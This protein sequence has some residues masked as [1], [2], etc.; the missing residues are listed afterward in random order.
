MERSFCA[1]YENFALSHI[2][3]CWKLLIQASFTLTGTFSKSTLYVLGK[4]PSFKDV[5]APQKCICMHGNKFR[6]NYILDINLSSFSDYRPSKIGEGFH[7]Y[8]RKMWKNTI[9]LNWGFWN[10]QMLKIGFP[11]FYHVSLISHWHNFI[12]ITSIMIFLIVLQLA[13]SKIVQK[14]FYL[15]FVTT[16]RVYFPFF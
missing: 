16:Y 14:H 10:R 1:L 7:M 12:T 11:W 9:F 3:K 8:G 5:S 2:E 15:R 6:E 4:P 13:F